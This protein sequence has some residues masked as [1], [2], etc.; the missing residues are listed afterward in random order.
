MAARGDEKELQ[1]AFGSRMK[2]G[3][4]GLR[5]SMGAGIACM[6]ELTVLQA[7]QG[8]AMYVATA[9]SPCRDAN[10]SIID[11]IAIN[12]SAQTNIR[13]NAIH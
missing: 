13:Q 4:A 7:S 6:N 3:T 11:T 8:L 1:A 12:H 2:F 5:S 10:E 9:P